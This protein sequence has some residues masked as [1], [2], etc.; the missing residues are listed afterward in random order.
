MRTTIFATLILVATPVAA[1]ENAATNACSRIDDSLERLR[2]FDERSPKPSFGL[3][4]PRSVQTLPV[5]GSGKLGSREGLSLKQQVEQCFDNPAA[6]D[7]HAS[8]VFAILLTPD[9]KLAEE[10]KIIHQDGDETSI[11]QLEFAGRRALSRCAPYVV[12]K[13]EYEQWKD[14]SVRFS[15][16]PS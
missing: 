15:R 6:A 5:H 3:P 14:V 7:R 12:P 4:P 10:P 11:R 16:D 13:G 8:V 9:G 2:C 1:Q